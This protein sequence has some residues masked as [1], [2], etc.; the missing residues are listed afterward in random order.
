MSNLTID[1]QKVYTYLIHN[2]CLAL[3]QTTKNIRF[4]KNRKNLQRAN[5]YFAMPSGTKINSFIIMTHLVGVTRK[6]D[7][8][9]VADTV[10]YPG[11]GT[12]ESPGWI[13]AEKNLWRCRARSS[14]FFE[15]L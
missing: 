15:F 9:D 8:G 6:E 4:L 2:S 13:P 3:S 14:T 5:P 12:I 11:V 7:E 1:N 10:A